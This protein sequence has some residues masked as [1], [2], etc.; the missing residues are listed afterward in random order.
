MNLSKL[1]QINTI[2]LKA[3]Y[4]KSRVNTKFA[5]IEYLKSRLILQNYKHND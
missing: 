1:Q 4:K 3:N 5:K 2:I